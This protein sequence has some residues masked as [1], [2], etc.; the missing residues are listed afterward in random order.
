VSTINGIDLHVE[1]TGDTGPTLVLVHGAWVDHTSWRLVA[2]ALAA[3][4][5]VVCYDRR[6]HSLSAGAGIGHGSRTQ[7]EDDLAA[8]IEALDLGPVH[9][10]G[11][12]YGASIA[13]AVAARRPDLVRAVVGHEPAL[14][15]AARPGSQLAD[16]MARV[17]T[18]LELVV[19]DLVR[20]KHE[21][22]AIRFIE[23]L[24]LGPGSWYA[25]PEQSRRVIVANALTFLELVSDPDWGTVPLPRDRDIA[26]LL[27][28]GGASPRWLPEIVSQLLREEYGDADHHTFESAGHAPHLTHPMQFVETVTSFIRAADGALTP[29]A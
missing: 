28:D 27:T 12:S 17:G 6:G 2:P 14:I 8:L 29:C 1:T 19:A 15:G 7:H 11:S 21:R 18:L 9:L 4:H 13:L 23:E 24:A 22:G 25:L 5:R 26:V 20:G 3:T 10:V 16:R